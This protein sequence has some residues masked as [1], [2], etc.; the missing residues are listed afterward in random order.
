MNAHTPPPRTTMPPKLLK[1]STFNCF[2][3]FSVF[4][5]A[6]MR[7]RVEKAFS[8]RG[9]MGRW[10]GRIAGAELRGSYL[11][12]F[13]LCIDAT[14]FSAW[15]TMGGQGRW[16]A[17]HRRRTRTRQ[18]AAAPG[19]VG[20][21]AG[22]PPAAGGRT[23]MAGRRGPSEDRRRPPR[24][25]KWSSLRD[26]WGI[27]ARASEMPNIC[28]QQWPAEPRPSPAFHSPRPPPPTGFK[29]PCLWH[30]VAVAFGSRPSCRRLPTRPHC[31]TSTLRVTTR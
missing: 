16:T 11:N 18:P 7:C 2:G 20:W 6:N 13:C 21:T 4:P 25:V 8:R 15:P 26:A 12:S 23:R 5:L 9:K 1:T 27:S 19:G 24:G 14:I 10:K 17:W 28:L 3:A 31:V 22:C 29:P 30:K